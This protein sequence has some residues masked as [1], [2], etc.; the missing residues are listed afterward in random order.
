VTIGTKEIVRRMMA[1]MQ[2]GSGAARRT[3]LLILGIIREAV[4]AGDEVQLRGL[5]RF[6]TKQ[7]GEKHLRHSRTRELYHVPAHRKA[8]FRLT[9]QMR[10]LTKAY[11]ANGRPKAEARRG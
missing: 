3:F 10:E 9:E 2:I 6:T 7:V 11:E 8:I 5:G 4:L 1:R